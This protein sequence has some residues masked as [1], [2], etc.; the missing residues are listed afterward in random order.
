MVKR[1]KPKVY[2][3]NS[4]AAA[5]LEISAEG[6]THQSIQPDT[7]HTESWDRASTRSFNINILEASLFQSVTGVP[8]PESPIDETTYANIG[9]PFYELLGEN[10]SEVKGL[11][12]R[13]RK[14]NTLHEYSWNEFSEIKPTRADRSSKISFRTVSE[15]ERGLE[16]VS[17]EEVLGP[18]SAQA[19]P[20]TI[21]V[22]NE[23]GKDTRP[24]TESK[25]S[26]VIQ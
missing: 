14:Q 16:S 3:L 21:D 24:E 5:Y 18:T 11:D 22:Q 10:L 12:E 1:L 17:Q 23:A 15:I 7:Y 25:S 2:P 4:E 20:V 26:C 13:D 19:A 8:P 9:I 6:L